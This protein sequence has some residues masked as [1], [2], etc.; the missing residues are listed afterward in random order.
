MEG[1]NCKQRVLAR[2]RSRFL[3]ILSDGG[4]VALTECNTGRKIIWGI[5]WQTMDCIPHLCKIL[6]HVSVELLSRALY[7]TWAICKSNACCKLYG[8]STPPFTGKDKTHTRDKYVSYMESR[9]IL[10]AAVLQ[11]TAICWAHFKVYCRFQHFIIDGG[12]MER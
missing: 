5:R 1:I 7:R 3:C 8:L 4:W 10:A 12:F 9:S 6:C 2:S 11:C